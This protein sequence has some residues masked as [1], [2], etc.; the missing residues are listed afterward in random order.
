MTIHHILR[1]ASN[2]SFAF[3]VLA[4]DCKTLASVSGYQKI[5]VMDTLITFF[6]IY[7]HYPQTRVRSGAL[8]HF[9]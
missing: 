4:L 2:C 7:A 8:V 5:T 6:F 9:Q 1:M 3:S